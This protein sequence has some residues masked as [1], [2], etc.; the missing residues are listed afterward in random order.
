[1]EPDYA[2]NYI[3]GATALPPK[4]Q[5]SPFSRVMERVEATQML[6]S[7]LSDLAD[8]LCGPTPREASGDKAQ[9]SAGAFGVLDSAC[10]D[11]SRALDRAHADI[12]RIER[13]LP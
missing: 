7:R 9:R 11:I 5:Q 3:G 10:D 6:A 13:A 12:Q 1:M 8:R 2:G 4:T